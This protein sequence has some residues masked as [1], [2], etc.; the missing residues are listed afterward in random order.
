M[1]VFEDGPIYSLNSPP[2][3]VNETLHAS[4]AFRFVDQVY[5]P[6]SASTFNL[7]LKDVW[8]GIIFTFTIDLLSPGHQ[9][10]PALHRPDVAPVGM[11]D[12]T[13]SL[14]P[15]AKG[16]SYEVNIIEQ[17]P[18]VSVL[19]LADIGRENKRGVLKFYLPREVVDDVLNRVP[20]YVDVDEGSGRVLVKRYFGDA[21]KL[22]VAELV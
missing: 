11:P 2:K 13:R 4:S 18:V 7:H 15:P 22:F 16:L 19:P 17:A 1:H 20:V 21:G 8:T 9:A 3:E 14:I 12:I 10:A 5:D 6:F